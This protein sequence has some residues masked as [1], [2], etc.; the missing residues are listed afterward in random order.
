[1]LDK[2]C[3]I[4]ENLEALFSRFQTHRYLGYVFKAHVDTEGRETKGR[5]KEDKR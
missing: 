5:E 2:T 1:M 3:N 4:L